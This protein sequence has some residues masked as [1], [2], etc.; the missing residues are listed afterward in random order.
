MPVQFLIL[1]L[2]MAAFGYFLM[3]NLIFNLVDAVWD[4]GTELLVKNNG[5]ETRIAL[6]EIIN[7]SY[8]ALTNPQRVTLTLRQPSI[9]GKEVTFAAPTVW[10]PFAKSP[11]IEDLIHRVDA[12]RRVGA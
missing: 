3:K 6:R 5:R 7:V 8:S 12:A 1:P 9:F 10:I 4:L 11:I 2:V